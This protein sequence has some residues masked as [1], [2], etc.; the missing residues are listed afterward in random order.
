[1]M[2]KKESYINITPIPSCVPRQLALDILHSHGEIITLNP[3]VLSYRPIKAPRDAAADEYYSTWYEI[4]ERV[5][6]VPGLGKL[7]S[8]KISFKGCFHNTSWGL[9]TH[10]FVPMGIDIRSKWRIGG[11]QPN[12]PRLPKEFRVDGEPENGLYLREDIQIEC[13]LTL[14][15]YVK[16]QMKAASKVLVDRLIKKAELL[17]AGVL[18]AF[19]EDGKL[20]TVNPANPSSSHLL[21]S[22][23]Q[24]PRLETDRMSTSSNQSM[25]EQPRWIEHPRWGSLSKRRTGSYVSTPSQHETEQ[26]GDVAAELPGSYFHPTSSSNSQQVYELPVNVRSRSARIDGEYQPYSPPK[27]EGSKEPADLRNKTYEMESA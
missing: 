15:S 8:G 18:Q 7:G 5:Q 19:M 21:Q 23:L 24:S 6:Y 11:N 10:T 14:V 27:R 12:E 2:R 4:T 17:D 1:M 9:Q 3:L 16:S 20:K 25:T 26:K 22:S 13:N